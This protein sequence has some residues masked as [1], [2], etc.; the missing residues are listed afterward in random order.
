MHLSDD[1]VKQIIV[2][3]AR[4]NTLHKH[5][6]V[7]QE[8]WSW[9]NNKRWPSIAIL[10]FKLCENLLHFQKLEKEIYCL[11][12]STSITILCTTLNVTEI[13]HELLKIKHTNKRWHTILSMWTINQKISLCNC[14]V[15]IPIYHD[16]Y[17]VAD[18]HYNENTLNYLKNN[19][20]LL[21]TFFFCIFFYQN[22]SWKI[23]KRII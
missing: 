23:R 3:I 8:K 14:N 17:V 11:N 5:A 22:W 12:N 2:V 13:V 6:R 15:H 20:I 7:Y 9:R 4:R 18:V 10:Y 19:F 21:R 16:L 1:L